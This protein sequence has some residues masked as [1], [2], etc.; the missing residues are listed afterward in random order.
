MTFPQPTKPPSN[1]FAPSATPLLDAL[2]SELANP[3]AAPVA[4]ATAAPDQQE[5]LAAYL[6]TATGPEVPAAPDL[7]AA[8]NEATP[9]SRRTVFAAAAAVVAGL[10]AVTGAAFAFSAY[11]RTPAVDVAVAPDRCSA[12]VAEVAKAS[13]AFAASETQKNNV[14][15]RCEANGV[16][17]TL[18][19]L[20]GYVDNAEARAAQATPATVAS[21]TTAARTTPRPAPP[22]TRPAPATTRVPTFNRAAW[23]AGVNR[24]LDI[25]GDSRSAPSAIRAAC[26]ALLPAS[27]AGVDYNSP[28]DVQNAALLLASASGSCTG[29]YYENAAEAIT[30]AYATGALG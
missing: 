1:P 11:D 25:I 22:T 3:L 4:I 30:A 5:R 15:G 19:F 26:A 27:T 24:Q 21:T 18:P 29:G 7:P 23:L 6:K 16:E 14:Y 28:I 9:T 17:A 12:L 8:P 20:K 2:R 13:P 10:I